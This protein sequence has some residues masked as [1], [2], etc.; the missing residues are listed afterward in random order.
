MESFKVKQLK[1]QLDLIFGNSEQAKEMKEIVLKANTVGFTEEEINEYK[2]KK[3]ED[4]G[5]IENFFDK[6]LSK[7]PCAYESKVISENEIKNIFSNEI[8]DVK[9][10]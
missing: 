2:K 4:I 7:L 8:L 5:A 6:D 10:E 3:E 9:S 1:S